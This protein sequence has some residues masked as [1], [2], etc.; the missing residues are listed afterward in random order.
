MFNSSL[1]RNA[2]VLY[3][4]LKETVH[5]VDI[6]YS[7]L[8]DAIENSDTHSILAIYANDGQAFA[9]AYKMWLLSKN[10]D[11]VRKPEIPGL[12]FMIKHYPCT[13]DSEELIKEEIARIS[14]EY[15]PRMSIDTIEVTEYPSQRH[16]DVYIRA[17]DKLSGL[18]SEASQGFDN[19]EAV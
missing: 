16:C 4:G 15:Y 2:T 13:K 7:N 19:L 12:Y 14:A 8:N 10:Y 9:N 11:Y 18:V 17:I 1:A 5:Y 6:K 3:S